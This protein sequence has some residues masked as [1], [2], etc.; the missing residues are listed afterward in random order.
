[1]SYNFSKAVGNSENAFDESW[2]AVG[3]I[4]D[5]YD[6]S[7]DAKTVVSYDQTHVFKG[8]LSYQMPFG[9]GRKYL[10][11]TSGIVNALLGGW[12]VTWVFRYSTGYPLA[13]WTNSWYP[14]W[15]G[16]VYADFN[17]G[18]NLDRQFTGNSFNPGQENAPGNLYFD[19]TAFSNPSGHNLGNGSRYYQELRGFGWSQEDLGL[20]KYWHFTETASLQFRFEFINV[21]N[22]HHYADPNTSLGNTTNFGYV[23]GMTGDPRN[24][25]FGLRFAW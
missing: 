3:N 20:L 10:A 18:A 11:G 23:T 13:V 14:G 25:Q 24:V 19:P 6:L 2:D 12:D 21:F 9:R 15:D 17:S 1:V 4:Q 22:R 7:K 8:Y 5:M 16:Q